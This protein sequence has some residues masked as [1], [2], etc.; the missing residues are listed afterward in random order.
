MDP[1][2]MQFFTKPYLS[3]GTY[4][5]AAYRENPP[6]PRDFKPLLWDSLFSNLLG[7]WI[8]IWNCWVIYHWPA[9]EH[10]TAIFTSFAFMTFNFKFH[11]HHHSVE[12]NQVPGQFSLINMVNTWNMT[13]LLENLF[14]GWVSIFWRLMIFCKREETEGCHLWQFT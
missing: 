10:V 2:V 14:S 1:Y 5:Y 9:F 6:L 8:Q 7:F 12:Q 4:V 13:N 11:L 3:S